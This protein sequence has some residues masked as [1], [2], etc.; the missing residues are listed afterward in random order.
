MI[1]DILKFYGRGNT[2]L[3]RINGEQSKEEVPYLA[4]LKIVLGFFV[5]DFT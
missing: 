4:L 3:V 2:Q 1:D 5:E